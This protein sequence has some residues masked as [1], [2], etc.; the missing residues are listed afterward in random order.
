PLIYVLSNLTERGD[1]VAFLKL[2][3]LNVVRCSDFSRRRRMLHHRYCIWH[4]A[5][6]V[7]FYYSVVTEVN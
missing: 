7:V 5:I 3:E 2:W 4:V 6:L 1:D